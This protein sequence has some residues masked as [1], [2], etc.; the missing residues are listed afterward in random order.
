MI[1]F[2]RL[3]SKTF[4]SASAIEFGSISRARQFDMHVLQAAMAR[5]PDPVPISSPDRLLSE[6]L[7]FKWSIAIRAS[8]VVGC[9]P[10]PNEMPGSIIIFISL[11]LC[12]PFIPA[13]VRTKRSV[14][15]TGLLKDN[16][17]YV[18]PKK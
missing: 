13:G 7:G 3:L 11:L 9:L 8:L 4:F 18:D 6:A 2:L 17:I 15:F 1:L 5:T 14:I 10:E 12:V 16:S